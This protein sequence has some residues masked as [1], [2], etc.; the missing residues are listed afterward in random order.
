[1][2]GGGNP[3]SV[4]TLGRIDKVYRQQKISQIQGDMY[5]MTMQ[6][7]ISTILWNY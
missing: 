5:H 2:G 4:V 3:A 1:M 6:L 7:Y